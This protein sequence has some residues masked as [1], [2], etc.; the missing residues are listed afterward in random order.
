MIRETYWQY[1][2]KLACLWSFGSKEAAKFLFEDNIS[3]DY[4]VFTD[5]RMVISSYL[6]YY[7]AF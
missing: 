3:E 7:I 6:K 4:R 5:F 1:R 2:D